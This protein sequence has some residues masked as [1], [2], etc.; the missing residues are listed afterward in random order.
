MKGILLK[1]LFFLFLTVWGATTFLCL[2][3]FADCSEGQYVD[4][5]NECQDCPKGHCCNGRQ[6]QQ[7]NKGTY[8][9]TV[10]TACQTLESSSCSMF[11]GGGGDVSSG[12]GT[13]G[14][15]SSS[16]ISVRQLGACPKKCNNGCTTEILGAVSWAECTVQTVSKFCLRTGICFEWPV[17]G[18]IKEGTINQKNVRLKYSC[19]GTQPSS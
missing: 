7:C 5:N 6:K 13:R 2:A 3:S 8:S 15:P 17:D 11:S 12:V 9:D 16:C 14:G 10:G 18:S 4:L 1:R 19:P